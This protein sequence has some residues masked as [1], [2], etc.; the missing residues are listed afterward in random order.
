[1]FKMLCQSPAALAASGAALTLLAAPHAI[2]QTAPVGWTTTRPA[3]GI[4]A[5]TPPNLADGETL[6]VAVSAP[7]DLGDRT[8]AAW[9]PEAMRTDPL[10]HAGDAKQAGQS[11]SPV[12]VVQF[13]LPDGGGAA[14]LY[15]AARP[16]LGTVQLI[17]VTMSTRTPV[18]DRYKVQVEGIIHSL[19]RG[20]ATPAPSAAPGRAK[21]GGPLVEGVYAGDQ[22]CHGLDGKDV[23]RRS[24]RLYLY[25][26]GEYRMCDTNGK[27]YTDF[28][29]GRYTYDAVSGLLMVRPDLY[30]Y[31]ESG[32]A[33]C[34]YGRDGAGQPM[35]QADENIFNT[36]TMLRH[37]GPA[38]LPSPQAEARAEA[39][40]KDAARERILRTGAGVKPS[41]IAGVWLE[42][43]LVPGVGGGMFLSQEPLLVLNDGTY[44]EDF[45]VP[46]A[47]FVVAESRR[48]HPTHWGRW[49]RSGKNIQTL[50]D[51]GWEDIA[52][53]GPLEAGGPGQRLSGTFTSIGGGGN[54]AF[55]GSTIVAVMKSFT[56]FPDGRFQAGSSVSA[57]GGGDYSGEGA[58][59][60]ATSQQSTRGTYTLGNYA[61]VLH[62]NDGTV[63]HWSYARNSA[64]LIFL[65]GTSF[66]NDKKL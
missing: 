4:V 26:D 44:C 55:G 38:P 64:D 19:G 20:L 2:A 49:R 43:L 11:V 56:F 15:S 62:F 42:Q 33:R 28:P 3:P 41:Q 12:Y 40:A 29:T 45:D 16:S 54:T 66:L 50:T 57:S 35:I 39:K 10:R 5:F 9:L 37:M 18:Y 65:N 63:L 61:L 36:T 25:A 22:V 59:A 23:W 48:A 30:L 32:E 24:Y 58:S 60:S 21:R 13:T 34:V 51:K 14:D 27:P 47:E 31:N 1:M 52:W 6:R 17:H 53:I 46:P 8:L 7:E